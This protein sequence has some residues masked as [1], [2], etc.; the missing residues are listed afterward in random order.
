M[1]VT[2]VYFVCSLLFNFEILHFLC[3]TLFLWKA[4]ATT[5]P[6]PNDDHRQR[7]IAN[8]N[9]KTQKNG[10]PAKQTAGRKFV[11]VYCTVLLRWMVVA[12]P[13]LV[14]IGRTTLMYGIHSSPPPP[15]KSI[16]N[17][18]LSVCSKV[19]P[20]KK[21]ETRKKKIVM[22]FIFAMCTVHVQWH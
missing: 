4:V 20:Q 5:E 8:N 3:L 12:W 1:A 6:H 11:L 19:L 17:C 7:T 13:V 18:I 15:P 9:N 16:P 14:F 2:W 22:Q 10:H 21:R